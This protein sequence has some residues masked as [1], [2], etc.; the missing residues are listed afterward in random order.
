MSTFLNTTIASFDIDQQTKEAEST[1]TQLE[2]SIIDQI[3]QYVTQIESSLESTFSDIDD[4]L[5]Y[6][7]NASTSLNQFVDEIQNNY[8]DINNYQKQ[9]NQ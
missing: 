3:E 1:L 4:N 5:L 2:N 6:I 9:V 8:Q 7:A